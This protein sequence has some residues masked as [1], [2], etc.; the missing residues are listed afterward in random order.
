MGSEHPGPHQYPIRFHTYRGSE[1][2]RGAERSMRDPYAEKRRPGVSICSFILLLVALGALW[3][4]GHLA[5]WLLQS[6]PPEQAVQATAADKAAEAAAPEP[7]MEQPHRRRKRNNKP[8]TRPGL[9]PAAFCRRAIG[10]ALDSDK[11]HLARAALPF[12]AATV[13]TLVLFA[14]TAWFDTI[15]GLAGSGSTNCWNCRWFSTCTGCLPNWRVA[16]GAGHWREF[17]C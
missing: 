3:K 12:A 15:G 9:Y 6:A 1:L 4:T 5:Q 13:F 8:K 2:P 10:F 17:R 7:R 16:A 14:L 11:S